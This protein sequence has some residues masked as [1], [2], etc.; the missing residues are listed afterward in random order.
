MNQKERMLNGLPYLAGDKDLVADRKK[1]QHF[2]YEY[3]NLPPSKLVERKEM[4]KDFLGKTG[5]KYHIEQ[6]FRC[7]YGYNIEVGERFYS[8]YNL[9]ILDICKVSIGDDVMFAPNVSLYTAGHPVHP[10]ARNSGY[11]YGAEIRI[12]NNVWLCGNVVVNPG[13]TIGDNTVIASGSVVTK[14]IP[15]NVIAGGNPCKVIREITDK[16]I[17]Y[18]RGNKKFDV[19]DYK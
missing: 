13:V 11:E 18:Y 7:D 5:K 16:D 1:A 9:T 4:L 2:C 3:N 14:D 12:G 19:D 6:P 17:D 10:E 15:A 8:N